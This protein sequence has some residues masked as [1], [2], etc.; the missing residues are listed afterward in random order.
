MTSASAVALALLLAG[1][2][3]S[4]WDIAKTQ[5]ETVVVYT[6]PA[7][8]D[9]LERDLLPAF[10][11]ETGYRVA[12]VYVAAGQQFNRLRMSGGS[13]EADVFLHAS[14][15]YLEKGYE[16]GYVDP[17][18][19]DA[20]TPRLDDAFQ[21]R[22]VEGGRIWRAFAWSPLVAVAPASAGAPP[23]LATASGAFGFPHPVL[24]NNGV[25]VVVFLQH[26]DDALAQRLLDATRVQPTNARTTIGG[27][28]EG[29][30]QFTLGYEGV[31]RFYEAQGAPIVHEIPLV[32]GEKA[33]LRVVFSAA[34]VANERRHP[35][36]DPLVRFLFTPEAQSLLAK[37]HLRPVLAG[38][39]PPQGALDLA[40]ATVH[41]VD[42]RAWD[43]IERALPLY[44]VK[45]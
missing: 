32:E 11:R 28:A 10:E 16:A 3:W 22:A 35:G 5:E 36:A 2:S 33:T 43:T 1:A 19:E 45:S 27:V 34:L 8:R 7:L 9:L 15:L 29:S 26:Y 42:W 4:L 30:F 39:T 31:A 38:A 21:S 14:P 24:S 18:R 13:P 25:Y 12:P 37:H 17:L 41:D 6:T 44:E 20:G 23:D 40:D